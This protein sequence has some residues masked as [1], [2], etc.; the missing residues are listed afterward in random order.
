VFFAK[1]MIDESTIQ[2]MTEKVRKGCYSL[3]EFIQD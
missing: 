3:I 2:T 1:T